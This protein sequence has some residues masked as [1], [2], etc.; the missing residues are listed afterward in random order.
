MGYGEAGGLP[1]PSCSSLP[2]SNP[3]QH[4]APSGCCRGEFP[5]ARLS[6][7][8]VSNRFGALRTLATSSASYSR[9]GRPPSSKRLPRRL[10]NSWHRRCMS[11]IDLLMKAG[12]KLCAVRRKRA[13]CSARVSLFARRNLLS[14]RRILRFTAAHNAVDHSFVFFQW[15]MSMRAYES[16]H[17][18]PR[19]NVDPMKHKESTEITKRKQCRVGWRTK[20]SNTLASRKQMSSPWPQKF[21]S[22]SKYAPIFAS[23]CVQSS[24]PQHQH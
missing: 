3:T 8:V 6:P 4:P 19:E 22:C 2:P 9:V 5:P 13:M 11:P 17:L 7:P 14:W 10:H 21:Q 1:E 23:P 18:C 20:L 15:Q 12:V 24:R 16:T